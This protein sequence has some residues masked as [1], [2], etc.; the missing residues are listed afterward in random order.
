MGAVSVKAATGNLAGDE[1]G[2]R[3]I[4]ASALA[5]VVVR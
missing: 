1:G 5:G 2:G 3:V 4:S